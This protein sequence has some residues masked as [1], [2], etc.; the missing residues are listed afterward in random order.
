MKRSAKVPEPTP[1]N[2]E[3]A[4]VDEAKARYFRSPKGK[5]ALKKYFESD[6]GKEAQE[7]YRE[8]TK[9]KLALRR[10]YHSPKGQEAHIRRKG[11]VNRFKDIE[12]WLKVNPGKTIEDYN[13]SHQEDDTTL[14]HAEEE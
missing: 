6:K 13:A 7:R 9:G 3:L 14:I 10:Y 2:D 5:E 1:E 12:K 8:S 4:S 11:K